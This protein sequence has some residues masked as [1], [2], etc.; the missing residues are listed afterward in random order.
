MS[1]HIA[2]ARLEL[3]LLTL[4]QLDLIAAG[5]SGPV[6][7]QIDAQLSDEW[8]EEV[9]W[10]AG[11]RASQLRDRPQDRPWL[12]RAIVRREMGA[13]REAIGYLNFHAGPDQHGMVE[14]GYTLLP[15]ARGRG[16]AIEAVQA[17]F[18]WATREHGVRRFRASV[19]PDNERSLNLIGKLGFV[20]TGEQWDERDGLEL[21]YQ[22]EI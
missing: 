9:R 20:H 3:P 7:E 13:P 4:A 17:A 10:L 22:L 14:I 15:G 6:A 1:D 18:E 21:V 8:V 2:T 19:A 5:D 16:Y 12:L 11:M